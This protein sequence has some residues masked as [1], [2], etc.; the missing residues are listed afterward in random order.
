M[1]ALVEKYALLQSPTQIVEL[2]EIF[3]RV[4]EYEA[5]FWTSALEAN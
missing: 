1:E 3:R 4:T 5:L 2:V